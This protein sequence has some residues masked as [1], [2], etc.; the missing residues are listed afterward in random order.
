MA[1]CSVVWVSPLGPNTRPPPWRR[2][3]AE[4]R[5]GGPS[6]CP[7]EAWAEPPFLNAPVSQ[8]ELGTDSEEP[9]WASPKLWALPQ[10]SRRAQTSQIRA[11]PRLHLHTKE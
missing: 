9:P 8:V 4:V 2:A 1:Q 10:V 3:S 5:Q 11:V 7:H 6:G